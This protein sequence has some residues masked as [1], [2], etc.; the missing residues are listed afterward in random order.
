MAKGY[1]RQ[2]SYDLFSN[3]RQI[4]YLVLLT[5]ER[6]SKIWMRK[7]VTKQEQDLHKK[8]VTKNWVISLKTLLWGAKRR[9]N[10]CRLYCFAFCQIKEMLYVRPPVRLSVVIGSWCDVSIVERCEVIPVSLWGVFFSK[11]WNKCFIIN[12]NCE[13][14]MILWQWWGR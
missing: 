8:K 11:K 10:M 3:K 14:C 4:H 1:D 9:R 5:Q 7:W 12:L 2:G 13:F 6:I